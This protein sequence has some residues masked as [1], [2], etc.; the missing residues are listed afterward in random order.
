[1]FRFLSPPSLALALAGLLLAGCGRPSSSPPPSTTSAP[2]PTAV[3]TPVV[4][5]GD[6]AAVVNGHAVPMSR[7]RLLLNLAVQQPG[8]NV[9]AASQQVMEQVILFELVQEY[10]D[11]HGI[12]LTTAQ[13]NN[14]MKSDI[15]SAGGQAK[16]NQRLAQL[17]LT[18]DEY[19][20]LLVPSLLG[21]LVEARISKAAIK[22]EPAAKVEHILI[23]T[24]MHR[25]KPRTDAQAKALAEQLLRQVQHGANFGT[26]AAHYSDDP[27]SATNGGVY[28]VFPHQMVPSF[29]Y[30]SF[31]LPLHHPAVI[32][33]QYGYHVIE[34]LWRG[35]ATP[36]AQQ[37]Q[38][39]QQQAFSTWLQE[40]MSQAKIRRI[41]R[42]G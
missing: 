37:A 11:T 1:M 20:Q 2:V 21:N 17:H 6:V 33:S 23:A 25:P 29:D 35:K 19:K 7:Y 10:A 38:Q 41:A 24:K 8:T 3:A 5:G 22:K 30:A 36:P 15:S 31:H 16:F 14:R 32:K 39:Q 42:V 28:T 13:I 18:Q 40:Q 12:H 4:R 34:V 26:L 9:K 27:G